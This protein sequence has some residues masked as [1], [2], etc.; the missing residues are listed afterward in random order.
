MAPSNAR[1]A[2]LP[3]RAR[4]RVAGEVTAARVVPKAGSPWL[5]LTV[6][7]G[8]G[9]FVAMYTGRRSI[10]G[11]KPG[12]V[13]EFVGVLREEGGRKMMLNPTYTIRPDV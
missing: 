3:L 8:S 9:Y 10:P 11:I 4:V 1:I 2:S 6:D 13:V 7:D 5:E 12:R